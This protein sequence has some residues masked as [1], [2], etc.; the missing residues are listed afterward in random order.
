M[1]FGRAARIA[2]MHVALLWLLSAW[3]LQCTLKRGGRARM[4]F[5]RRH[6]PISV[7]KLQ[8]CTVGVNCTLQTTQTCLR[9]N[10]KPKWH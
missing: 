2:A 4:S 1:W 9:S 7:A 6:S 3:Q 8:C 5:T 10:Y